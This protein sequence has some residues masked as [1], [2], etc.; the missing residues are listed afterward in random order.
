MNNDFF[1]CQNCG[2]SHDVLLDPFVRFVNHRIDEN[3]K[4]YKCGV[5]LK[6]YRPWYI[7]IIVWLNEK[8]V[9][10]KESS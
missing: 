7:N 10:Q 9:I 8:F 1:Y 6:V 4:C 5:R 2:K 3:N